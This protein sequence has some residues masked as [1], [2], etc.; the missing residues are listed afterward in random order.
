MRAAESI[1]SKIVIGDG[2]WIGAGTIVLP[3]VA[4]GKG[5]VV[6]AGSTV[7]HDVLPNTLV[8]GVPARLV[9][10]LDSSQM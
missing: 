1:S 6:A 9:R 2:A 4:I 7:T 3:G 10:Q 8:A 5:A